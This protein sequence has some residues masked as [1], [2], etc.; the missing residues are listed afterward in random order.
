VWPPI[1]M[2]GLQLL[3]LVVAPQC[4]LPSALGTWL[5]FTICSDLKVF[6]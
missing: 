4:A 3:P 2:G 5:A 1:R 6:L